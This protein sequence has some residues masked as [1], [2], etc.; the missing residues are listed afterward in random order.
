M[1]KKTVDVHGFIM[2]HCDLCKENHLVYC[3]NDGDEAKQMCESCFNL[4]YK[5][6]KNKRRGV[7]QWEKTKKK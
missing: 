6:K 5:M 7:F 4:I 2:R 3:F 1:A